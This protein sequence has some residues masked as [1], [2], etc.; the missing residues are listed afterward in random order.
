M[1]MPR[2]SSTRRMAISSAGFLGDDGREPVEV[3]R[4][5]QS[6]APVRTECRLVRQASWQLRYPAAFPDAHDFD[7][8]VHAH[9]HCRQADQTVHGG[10]QFRHL[11]HLNATGQLRPDDTTGADQDDGHQPQAGAWADQRCHHGNRH[12]G[13]TV[14]DGA[15]RTFLARQSPKGK[16]QQNGGD[17]I[18]RD[19]EGVI[20]GCPLRLRFL[21]HGEHAPCHHEAAEY[22]DTRHEDRECGQYHH[23]P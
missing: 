1:K 14:P 5:R 2:N 16:D 11:R 3:L 22:V 6:L 17:D 10:D 23:Q 12:T 4:S 8:R 21:E 18:G 7:M 9:E 20:H 19:R 13:N 15:F